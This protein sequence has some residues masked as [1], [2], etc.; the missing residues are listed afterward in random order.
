MTISSTLIIISALIA[1]FYLKRAL[2]TDSMENTHYTN[3]SR[4][5]NLYIGFRNR[6]KL[7]P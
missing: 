4:K 5:S 7:S 2:L 6:A 1:P 3:A